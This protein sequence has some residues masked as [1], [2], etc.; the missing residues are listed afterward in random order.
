MNKN[1]YLFLPLNNNGLK[2][3]SADLTWV[4]EDSRNQLQTVKG[5]LSDAAKAAVDNFITVVFPGED[6]SCNSSGALCS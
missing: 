6:S 4:Y 1:F 3:E 2:L 5:S